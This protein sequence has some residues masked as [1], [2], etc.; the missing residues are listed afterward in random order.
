MIFSN[1]QTSFNALMT[2]P[3]QQVCVALC[4]CVSFSTCASLRP[5][6]SA[7]SAKTDVIMET[8]KTGI[9]TRGGLL[10]RPVSFHELQF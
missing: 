4:V 3:L 10:Q 5:Q 2:V 6:T 7:S 9:L 8:P 1:K